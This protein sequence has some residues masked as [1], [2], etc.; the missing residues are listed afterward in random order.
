MIYRTRG[1]HADYYN[2]LWFQQKRKY[3]KYTNNSAH[4]L[5]LEIWCLTPLS[6]IFQLYRGGQFYLWR[7]PLYLEKNH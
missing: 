7:K 4:F 6:T 5:G 3:Q 1:E 2:S